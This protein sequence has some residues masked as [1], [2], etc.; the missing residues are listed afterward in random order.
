MRLLF[1]LDRVLRMRILDSRSSRT[2]R[3][4]VGL[5]VS[6]P[7]QVYFKRST[8]D[9]EHCSTLCGP[10]VYKTLALVSINVSEHL[11]PL[12]T[13]LENRVLQLS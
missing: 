9:R 8:S 2:S 6:K 7:I 13:Y 1:M 10:Y 4:V 3:V 12:P 5:W 11:V